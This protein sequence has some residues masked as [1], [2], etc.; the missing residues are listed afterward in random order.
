MDEPIAPVKP[1]VLYGMNSAP[2]RL[3]TRPRFWPQFTP[4]SH[5]KFSRVTGRTLRLTS[6]P[7]FE[8]SPALAKV[9]PAPVAAP[10][11]GTG[12][13]TSVEFLS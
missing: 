4:T 13:I 3:S 5:A 11:I 2:A 7:L 8:T 9:R 1:S 10:L 6:Y 12:R